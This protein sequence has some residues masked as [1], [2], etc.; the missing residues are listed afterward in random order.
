MPSS[1]AEPVAVRPSQGRGPRLVAGCVAVLLLAAAVTK[2]VNP[3]YFLSGLHST[4]GVYLGR[5]A[6]IA[7]VALESALAVWLVSGR[8][9]RAALG[10]ALAL[11]LVFS[12]YHTL[13]LYQPQQTSCGC[14][15]GLWMELTGSRTQLYV[16]AAAAY[17]PA[18]ALWNA[19]RVSPGVVRSSLVAAKEYP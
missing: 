9:A 5:G 19:W 3:E 10:S 6:A 11:F 13:V 2:A 18:L 15:G 1:P 12:A 8:A 17:L 7:V 14:F 4:F 16:E